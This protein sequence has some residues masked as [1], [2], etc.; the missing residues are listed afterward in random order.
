MSFFFQRF[1]SFF[2]K[3]R[4]SRLEQDF[5]T[6]RLVGIDWCV[7]MAQA[8]VWPEDEDG[9]VEFETEIDDWTFS[10]CPLAEDLVDGRLPLLAFDILNQ[11]NGV[12]NI[13]QHA[14]RQAARRFAERGDDSG[15]RYAMMEIPIVLYLERA[16]PPTLNYSAV[17]V[18]SEFRVFLKKTDGTWLPFYDEACTPPAGIGNRKA[19]WL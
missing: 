1:S 14:C 10:V 17:K 18:N 7:K 13:V 8:K 19:V 9:Y 5:P 6:D 3:P 2:E 12:D 11:L 4:Q 16:C 15:Y